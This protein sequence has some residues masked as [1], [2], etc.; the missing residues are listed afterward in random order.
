MLLLSVLIH[1][2]KAL[3]G[4]GKVMTHI[5]QSRDTRIAVPDHGREDQKA[6]RS[7]H[8]MADQICWLIRFL[9]AMKGTLFIKLIIEWVSWGG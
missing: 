8:A 9:D 2:R 7:R 1:T 5:Q 6:Q 4:L 3:G